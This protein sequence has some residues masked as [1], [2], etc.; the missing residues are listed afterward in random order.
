MGLCVPGLAAGD[1]GLSRDLGADELG[2]GGGES[3]GHLACGVCGWCRGS[4]CVR[5]MKGRCEPSHRFYSLD[6]NLFFFF[7]PW[8]AKLWNT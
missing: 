8:F 5:Y 3:E 6:S 7:S 4:G 1:G 2:G